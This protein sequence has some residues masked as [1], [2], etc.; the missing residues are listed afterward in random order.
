MIHTDFLMTYMKVN[1]NANSS[2]E[3]STYSNVPFTYGD[4]FPNFHH[5][6]ATNELPLR[7]RNPPIHLCDYHCFS[8]CF[9][10]MKHN[11]IRNLLHILIGS[12]L[13]RKNYMYWRK[14]TYGNFFKPILISLLKCANGYIK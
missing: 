5:A 2:N 9:N 12:M 11:P 8:L 1:T 10:F 4:V 13:C 14:L 7:V 6:P 3:I